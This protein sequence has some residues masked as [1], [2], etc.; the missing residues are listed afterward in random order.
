[1]CSSLGNVPKAVGVALCVSKNLSNFVCKLSCIPAQFNL[2]FSH[3]AFRY[4]FCC[5]MPTG[6]KSMEI[7]I[8]SKRF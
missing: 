6:G 3:M 8:F 2:E 5:R 7:Y 1:M 4:S